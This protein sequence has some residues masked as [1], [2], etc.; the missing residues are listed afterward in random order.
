M[1]S[2]KRKKLLK[3]KEKRALEMNDFGK[4]SDDYRQTFHEYVSVASL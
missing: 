2:M 1:S 4:I 3:I